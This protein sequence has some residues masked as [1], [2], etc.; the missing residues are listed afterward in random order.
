MSASSD[1]DTDPVLRKYAPKWSREQPATPNAERLRQISTSASR[2]PS[3]EEENRDRR[4][5]PLWP[6]PH[7]EPPSRR[8]DG[9]LALIG[10]VVTVAAVAAL[11]ALFVIFGKPLLQRVGVLQP[12][13][14]STQISKPSDSVTA[15]DAPAT[16]A[17][18]PAGI[19]AAP[20][21]ASPTTGQTQQVPL[22]PAQGQQAALS[23]TSKPLGQDSGVSSTFRGVTDSEIR[24][25]FLHLSLGP[26]RNS[27]SI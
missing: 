23:P 5:R 21:A 6:G 4:I 7:A 10:R 12:D 22:S 16:R 3:F 8:A 26:P 18:V 15:N 20:G 14:P 1:D 11:V 27:A 24:L 17:L 19:A 25:G 2:V 13:S 9:L